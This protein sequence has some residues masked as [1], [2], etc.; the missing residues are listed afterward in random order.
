MRAHCSSGDGVSDSVTAPLSAPGTDRLC[1][2]MGKFDNKGGSF[3]YGAPHIDI[4]PMSLYYA[5]AHRQSQSR[6]L[7]VKK[8]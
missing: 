1:Y 4:T 5:I 3:P 2:F 7:V 8:G 6:S